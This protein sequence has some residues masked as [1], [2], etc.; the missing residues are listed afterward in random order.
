MRVL[1]AAVAAICAFSV[2]DLGAQG[3]LRG[4]LE[5][6]RQGRHDEAIA[7]AVAL[8]DLGPLR[9]QFV[10][11]TPGWI[12]ADP[13]DAERRRAVVAAFLVE[14]A[15]ARLE[16]DWGRLS[17]LIEWTC[18]QVLRPS[19]PP[20]AFERSWHMATTA[21]AGRARVR[22]W[23]LGPY[24]RLPHQKPL[25]RVPQKDDP[26]SPLHLMHAIERF[27]DDPEFQLARVIAWTWGRDS[28]P[29]RNMRQEWRDNANRWGPSRPPQLE[30]ITA[31][32]PLIAMPS[33]AAEAHIRTGLIHVTVGDQAA[34]LK[35]FEAAQPIARTTQ[36]KYLA[37]FLAGRSLEALQRQDEAIAQYRRALDIV[38]GAESATLA[39]ASLQFLRG[40]AE[41]AIAR[42]NNTFAVSATTT[43]PGRLVGY[44]F[45]LHWPEIKAAMRAE[46][47]GRD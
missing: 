32:E 22:V 26:P 35:S 6:Y 40:D 29:M 16:S 36:L 47:R 42:I 34:A 37:H 28:E 10:Q 20:T 23:L 7:K 33:I 18:A 43:D 41:T 12:A 39:L 1:A 19:G 21:L 4:L 9:L 24:A 2:T 44:G 15:A 17:D 14:L 45:Y 38:P 3:A 31:F 27:P 11:Q 25:K 8:P 13:A 46:L 5:T 30:A